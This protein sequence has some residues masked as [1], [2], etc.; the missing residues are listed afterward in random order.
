[1]EA[2]MPDEFPRRRPSWSRLRERMDHLVT[3]I[4]PEHISPDPLEVVRR[5]HDPRDVEV[6]G[7]L[8][9]AL[10]F[11]SARGA[12]KSV[13]ALLYRFDDSPAAAVG[14]WDAARDGAMLRGWRHRWLGERDASAT[15]HILGRVVRE[16][17]P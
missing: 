13:E 16:H 2:A 3:T 17:G 4:G 14:A 9:A 10:A 5:F 7:F 12:V 1:M 15:L 8:A 11:G 6:V